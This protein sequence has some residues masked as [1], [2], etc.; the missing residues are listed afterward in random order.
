MSAISSQN[1]PNFL[2]IEPFSNCYIYARNKGKN[3]FVP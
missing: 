1:L 3:D 2:K